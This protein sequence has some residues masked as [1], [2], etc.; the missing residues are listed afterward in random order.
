[1]NKHDF[2]KTAV[3]TLLLFNGALLNAQVTIGGNKAPQPFS[4]LELVSNETRGLRLPQIQDTIQR[5]ALEL[6]FGDKAATD[7]MGLQIFNL[8]T[9]CVETWNGAG[10][11]AA[12][13]PVAPLPA[14]DCVMING[15][16]WA[17]SNV[18]SIGKFAVNPEDAGMFYQWNKNIGWSSTNPM[19]NSNGGTVWDNTIAAGTEWE[20][21]NSPCPNGWHVP[22]REELQSL[23]DTEK[24][25]SNW[26]PK[27]GINGKYFIDNV[28]N[29]SIFLPAA[30][31][32]VHIGGV[33][34]GSGSNG[35]YWSS[36][37]YDSNNAY[38]L[39][40]GSG[41]ADISSSSSSKSAARLVR[42]VKEE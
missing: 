8:Q 9:K 10:W 16:C 5:K 14:P 28:T 18:D 41:S 32:R 35:Y 1:M 40:F 21:E 29:D 22:T 37:E 33:L 11:I 4:V 2:F 38:R 25:T 23:L 20:A 15:V 3:V 27:N 19:K 7:A 12:C 26:T 36:M 42:C 24:V 31:Y 17:K 6:S 39:G 30:G 34:G 13:A